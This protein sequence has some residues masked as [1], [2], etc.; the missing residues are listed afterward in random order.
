MINLSRKS[1]QVLFFAG[2]GA[3][4][5]LTHL[6]VVLN[7]VNHFAIEPLLAN[8]IAFFI[9]F[10]V[11]YLGHRYLSFSHLENKKQLSLPHFFL[12]ASSA[13][14]LNELLYFLLLKYSSV[15]YLLALVVV[16][17]LVAIYS[18]LLSRF[19]ACR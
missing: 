3:G 2:V 5:A 18:F 17:G 14:A 16:L 7:L 10:N 4:A 6:L 1:Q 15:H 13:G 11:S 9:A 8:L 19:W 12:V